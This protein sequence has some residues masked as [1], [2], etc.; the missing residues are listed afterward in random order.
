MLAFWQMIR[1]F[2]ITDG[3]V[4]PFHDKPSEIRQPG[5]ELS[6]LRRFCMRTVALQLHRPMYGCHKDSAFMHCGLCK[7]CFEIHFQCREDLAPFWRRL[8]LL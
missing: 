8:Q 2:N 4:R 5:D 3:F 1:R 7:A 6:A